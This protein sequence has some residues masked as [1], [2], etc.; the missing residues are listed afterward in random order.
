[1]KLLVRGD[2]YGFSR[3]CTLGMLDAK[4]NGILTCTG[5]FTN[6]PECEHAISLMPNYPDLCFGI[7]FNIVS[8]PC[9][10][11]P[12]LIPTLVDKDGNFI[13]SRIKYQDPRFQTEEGK[14]ELWPKDEVRI[15]LK[16]QYDK[17]VRLVGKKPEYVHTHS[18]GRTVP[19]YYE[20]VAEIGH[21]NDVIYSHEIQDKFG[22]YSIP[23]GPNN[24]FNVKKFDLEAQLNLD[25]VKKVMDHADE[26]LKHEYVII[27]GHPGFL[28]QVLLSGITTLS[29]ERVKDH[30]MCISPIIKKW[31]K[32]N[33]ITLI[34]YRDLV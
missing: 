7:D 19:T 24:H 22:F 20:T 9:V 18:I 10:A 33:N 13:L 3:G 25:M 32:D 1:M 16:A 2:D 15:E 5:L 8:G 6:M 4:E 23:V 31:V 11:D 26:L 21:E 28:D 30:A 27:G 29:I 34:S 14:A 12:K 17:Y